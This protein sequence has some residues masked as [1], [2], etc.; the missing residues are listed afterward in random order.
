MTGLGLTLIGLLIVL[1]LAGISQTAPVS[2]DMDRM[3]EMELL[4]LVGCNHAVT[5]TAL[6]LPGFTVTPQSRPQNSSSDSESSMD[7]SESDSVS[8]ETMRVR[9]LHTVMGQ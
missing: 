9:R 2:A 6:P 4:G 1:C 8:K 7:T 5:V 3:E